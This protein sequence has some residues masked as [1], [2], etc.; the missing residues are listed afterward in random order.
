MDP[1]RGLRHLDLAGLAL[2][3]AVIGVLALRAYGAGEGAGDPVVLIEASGTRW[4]YP[5]GEVRRLT[6]NG[7]L[8]PESIAIEDGAAFTEDCTCADRVCHR[9]GRISKP[10][11]WIACVP[12]KLFLRVEGLHTG[13]I[14]AASY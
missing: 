11:Q 4:I 9:Q 10:G 14:D 1:G 2:A 8:G 5:L 12:N 6:L 13:G 3:L 7:P